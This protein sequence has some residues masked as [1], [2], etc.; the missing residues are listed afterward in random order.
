[1][2]PILW[3]IVP[4]IDEPPM[5]PFMAPPKVLANADVPESASAVARAMVAYFM[6]FSFQVRFA[7][8]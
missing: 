7:R 6:I 8:E 4:F 5:W 1:M 2:L 3:L